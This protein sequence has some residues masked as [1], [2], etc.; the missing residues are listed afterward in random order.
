MGCGIFMGTLLLYVYVSK[1]RTMAYGAEQSENVI[2]PE[3]RVLACI[4]FLYLHTSLL[5]TL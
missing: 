4:T 1:K 3:G 5:A 2:R